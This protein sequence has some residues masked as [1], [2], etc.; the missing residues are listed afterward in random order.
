MRFPPS[1]H[2]GDTVALV[3]TSSPPSPK[4]AEA[5]VRRTVAALEQRGY[6]VWQAPSLRVATERGYAAA[7][8]DMRAADLHQAFRD[9]AIRAVWAIRGGSTAMEL[10]PL[11]DYELI[12]ANPKPFIGFSDVTALHAVLPQRCGFV[13]FHG[14][15]AKHLGE[16][17]DAFTLTSLFHTLGPWERL[18][19]ENPPDA[20]L[21]S[22]RGG[23]AEGELTGGNLSLIA[24]LMGTPYQPDTRGRL[25]FLEDVGEAVYR[26]DRLLRQ[27]KL[28]GLFADAAGVVLG[29]FTNCRNGYREEYGAAELLRDFFADYDKP[30]LAGLRAGHCRPTVTLPM[31]CRGRL[32]GERGTL[33]LLRD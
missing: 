20:P 8:A 31:G 10:L 25:L 1:F 7:P 23:V 6:R 4:D 17:P 18:T 29:D 32:D 12:R 24:A 15:V 5:T 26:L 11:L 13:T 22:L 33:T 2:A 28:G 30:V 3:A 16:E 9:P 21:R 27:L 19:V 14:P